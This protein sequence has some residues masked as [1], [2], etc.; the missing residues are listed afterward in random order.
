MDSSE[1]RC[2]LRLLAIAP[3]ALASGASAAEPPQVFPHDN[4]QNVVRLP[5]GQLWRLASRF[6]AVY[7]SVSNDHG[8]TWQGGFTTAY[9]LFDAF[10][11]LNPQPAV[12]ATGALHL[13]V[14]R[15]PE[16][17]P[18]EFSIWHYR[19]NAARTSWFAGNLI[20]PGNTGSMVKALHTSTGR[21]VVPFGDKAVPPPPGHGSNTT[22]VRYADAGTASF[23]LSDARLISPVPP[24]WNGA[25][26][27]AAEPT[28]IEKRD[29]TLWM[30]ARSQTGKLTESTSRDRG[31]TWTPLVDSRFHTSTGPPNLI[32]MDNGDMVLL[33]NNAIMPQRHNGKVWYAGRD[34]LH[35]AVSRDDGQTWR[36]FREVYLDPFRNETPPDGDTGTAYSFAAPTADGRIIAITG[37]AAAKAQLRIDPNWLM[38]RDRSDDFTAANALANWSVFKPYGDVVNV[39]RPRVQ[40]AQLIDDPDPARTKPVL[41]VRRPDANDPDGA[42]WNFPAAS[43]GQASVRI[44][45][46]SGF[47]GGAIGLTDRF[48]N[49]TDPQG[50]S[51]AFYK[52]SIAPDGAIPEIPGSPSLSVER[53]YTLALDYKTDAGIAVLRIDGTPVGTL[54]AQTGASAWPGVSYLRLR[55]TAPGIDSAG[56]LVDSVSNVA[57]N[58]REV[59]RLD[60]ERAELVLQPV[61]SRTGSEGDGW[62]RL[63]FDDVAPNRNVAADNPSG[64]GVTGSFGTPFHGYLPSSA[65]G[66]G[67]IVESSTGTV[68]FTDATSARQTSDLL[69]PK[70]GERLFLRFVDAHDSST[71][72]AV[73]EVVWRLGSVAPDNVDVRVFDVNGLELTDFAF[74]ALPAGVADA[75]GLVSLLDGQPA[76]LIHA[77]MFTSRSQDSWLIGSF[78]LD[79]GLNDLAYRGFATIPEP[80]AMMAGLAAAAILVTRSRRRAMW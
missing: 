5:D 7:H 31:I 27:G 67:L 37:Q 34:V 21:L 42:T 1:R 12:D 47:A 8:L 30:L 17:G 60:R 14:P 16:S 40:G 64:N 48:F 50:E 38:E 24:N 59:D 55:S 15:R 70:A 46:Q 53:W 4:F 76:P 41:H 18:I 35:A 52:L 3:V 22:L 32:R 20:H 6:N 74:S 2:L 29:G 57:A 66:A 45:L 79:T 25:A 77:V 62:T 80:A 61:A 69:G 63:R 78:S 43:R 75:G 11:G 51:Q 28:V 19:S 68:T 39:K 26:D 9:K 54:A 13:F 58:L 36:G 49:P 33:W 65:G 10:G 71:P 73:E 44:R 23:A 72:A 56:F